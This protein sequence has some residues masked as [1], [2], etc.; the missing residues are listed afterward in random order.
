ML[1]AG[2]QKNLSA[3]GEVDRY[4]KTTTLVSSR[5]GRRLASR[6]RSWHLDSTHLC[7][8]WLPGFT[9]PSPSTSLDEKAKNVYSIVE[10]NIRILAACQ[11]FHSRNSRS[12]QAGLPRPSEW[13]RNQYFTRCHSEER[14]DEESLG[15]PTRR[16]I[17][18]LHGRLG[19]RCFAALSMTS[20]GLVDTRFQTA[21][22]R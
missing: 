18:T 13:A 16:L 1:R 19:Q 8:D 17:I 12:G 7:A 11:G 15:M 2:K 5:S 3:E 9:G 6:R 14:S 21:L 10:D 22:A 20:S 4:R